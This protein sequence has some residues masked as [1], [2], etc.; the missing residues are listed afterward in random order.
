MNRPT[1][2]EHEAPHVTTIWQEGPRALEVWSLD[3]ERTA[4]LRWQGEVVG[5]YRLPARLG[6]RPPAASHS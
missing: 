6:Q 5:V 4:V 3:G 2:L 1:P